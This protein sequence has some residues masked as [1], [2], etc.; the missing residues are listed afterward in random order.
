MES[1]WPSGARGAYVCFLSNPQNLDIGS[2][3]AR[4]RE[5]PFALALRSSSMVLVLPNS[6]VSIHSRQ[7]ACDLH[8]VTV[9]LLI[10]SN[11]D[12]RT[13][14]ILEVD[15]EVFLED[16]F[17]YEAGSKGHESSSVEFL[18]GCVWAAGGV[19]QDTS[20]M[21]RLV[22]YDGQR[23]GEAKNPGPGM[24]S[25]QF[26]LL[27]SLMQVLIQMVTKLMGGDGE[28]AGLV[29]KA[30]SALTSLTKTTEP[31]PSP[32]VRSV[33]LQEEPEQPWTKVS[34]KRRRRKDALPPEPPDKG[35]GKGKNKGGTGA[36]ATAALP[37]ANKQGGAS[38]G[39]RGKGVGEAARKVELQAAAVQTEGA[40]RLRPED[41]TGKA[42]T[43]E[44]LA[45]YKGK[46]ES[47][48][49]LAKDKEEAEV[50]SV[51]A[52]NVQSSL[53]IIWR[54]DDGGIQLPFWR[55]GTASL[56]RVSVHKSQVTGVALPALK[57]ERTTVKKIVVMP[58]VVL[59]VI[60]VKQMVS[61]EVWKQ[62]S[63]AFRKFVVARAPSVKD[64]WGSATES[65]HG[66]TLVALT[67]VAQD[68]AEALLQRSGQGGLF[69]EP[70]ARTLGDRT[71]AVRWI[72][73]EEGE[74]DTLYLQRC[75]STKPLLGLVLGRR[76]LGERVNQAEV[77]VARSWRLPGT[78]R[79]W[80]QDTVLDLLKDSGLTDVTITS[81]MTRKGMVTWFLRAACQ[82]D[83]VAL[84]VEDGAKT[85]FYYV[86]PA[87]PSRQGPA[88]RT[89]LPYE[90]VF[91]LRGE[92]FKLVPG[93]A[94]VLPQAPP[95][96]AK[97]E[98]QAKRQAVT[99]R[100][101]PDG[102]EVIEVDRDG[103]CLPAA[104]A[105][106][107]AWHKNSTKVT[108][109][110]Q[111]RAE[112]VAYMTRKRDL[113]KDFWDG[114]NTND[115]AGILPNFEAYL[116]EAA[117]D[118]K[119]MGHLELEAAC[120]LFNLTVFV[121]PVV[122]EQAPT[123]HG[124]GSFPVALRY[125]VAGNGSIGHYDLLLPKDKDRG[126]PSVV[127]NIH[128]IGESKG[129][130][131]GG[132]NEPSEAAW[133][134][135]TVNTAGAHVPAGRMG[136]GLTGSEVSAAA[137]RRAELPPKAPVPDP[138]PA[139]SSSER[140][141]RSTAASG[142][143]D[144][145][146]SRDTE[147]ARR[148]GMNRM[149]A[150]FAAGAAGKSS[151]NVSSADAQDGDADSQDL[152]NVVEAKRPAQGKRGRRMTWRCKFCSFVTRPT[153]H[154]AYVS[155]MRQ[156][157]LRKWHPDRKAQWTSLH[158]WNFQV[159]PDAAAACSGSSKVL[160]QCK[161]CT[162]GIVGVPCGS[163]AQDCALYLAAV[164]HC[165]REH[166]EAPK[167]WYKRTKHNNHAKATCAKRASG[168]ARHVLRLKAG[169]FGDHDVVKFHIPF[170]G[171]QGKKPRKSA[172]ALVCKKC[173]SYGATPT[174][175]MQYPCD[176]SRMP[177]GRK[178]T[179]LVQKL[180]GA[181]EADCDLDLKRGAQSV[182]DIFE[183]V[184]ERLKAARAQAAKE[185]GSAEHQ[186]KA[187]AWPFLVEGATDFRIRFVCVRCHWFAA[188][189]GQF[190]DVTCTGAG[191]RRRSAQKDKLTELAGMEDPTG[192]AAQLVLKYLGVEY[193]V[194]GGSNQAQQ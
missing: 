162:A 180:R 19:A 191:K 63:E 124:S 119:Y 155:F 185:D 6:K 194:H 123:R 101:A 16:D 187:V 11:T 2:L 53:L 38:A 176:V 41:W 121:I 93:T 31:A 76:Q 125:E 167:G 145:R 110:L 178:R 122:A 173:G 179:A 66:P 139:S 151:G 159:I 20:R 94:Q 171:K 22:G 186:L 39:P 137:A 67:R 51:M 37:S 91:P 28:V 74:T 103:N 108:S 95:D 55:G 26:A 36:A 147:D 83:V 153:A 15:I 60:L 177:V 156:T 18:I 40:W 109:A 49:I 166:P 59:R 189:R 12:R 181:L 146:V 102:T 23:V 24:E 172:I 190:K 72:D 43:M 7:S 130:R 92:Q 163:R 58:T 73:K 81:R 25:E 161:H 188:K 71:F 104:L 149:A 154:H 64:M 48:F 98:S 77:K 142:R 157:H 100:A 113:F 106:A 112:L 65:K 42:V 116:K 144:G 129:G 33:S 57:G 140:A 136:R 141:P 97:E 79:E 148:T 134:I 46:G 118:G 8:V 27:I 75:L 82:E 96:G 193:T 165:K 3:I 183:E 5:S 1:S 32:Q 120:R 117:G 21:R 87:N 86:L 29:S 61:A 84:K 44:E 133:T 30:N 158:K 14:E 192:S 62:A 68:Q 88:K 114:R 126:Y 160:W 143:G 164:R 4:P 47:L 54:D 34:R 127:S 99:Q 182:L 128:E 131:G 78:P 174:S 70:T 107:I 152:D 45:E 115:E 170:L 175:L 138:L 168:V 9:E 169:A 111:L 52:G 135:Y 105:K 150:L 89:P 132:S 17:E 10:P 184:T 35:N 13:V 69:W 90:G 50:L 85:C 56:L 80:T